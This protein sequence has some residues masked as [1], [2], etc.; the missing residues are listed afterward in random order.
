MVLRFEMIL[1][2]VFYKRENIIF[3]EKH[4][5]LTKNNTFNNVFC[6]KI[7]PCYPFLPIFLELLDLYKSGLIF[8]VMAIV[9][10]VTRIDN[11]LFP[12]SVTHV[13]FLN[14][15]SINYIFTVCCET[16]K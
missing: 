11:R 4:L 6:N 10:L 7:F 3:Y 9:L 5:K 15:S 1:S 13:I 16:G 12:M 14:T 8:L 2:V